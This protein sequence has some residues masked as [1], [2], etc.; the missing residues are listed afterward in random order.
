MIVPA[1]LM[2][3]NPRSA[4]WLRVH[5]SESY[6]SRS[7]HSGTRHSTISNSGLLTFGGRPPRK[8]PD[9][10]SPSGHCARVDPAAGHAQPPGST[11]PLM[12]ISLVRASG[13]GSHRVDRHIAPLNE[14]THPPKI[15]A[16]PATPNSAPNKQGQAAE[17]ARISETVKLRPVCMR[18]PPSPAARQPAPE[19][20]LA[21]PSRRSPESK[22]TTPLPTAMLPATSRSTA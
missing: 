17:L 1:A 13:S 15:S 21:C 9:P 19:R 3:I 4:S 14:P 7:F 16:Y 8:L 10:L 2:W 12:C 20:Y 5:P 18:T 11:L 22:T 6:R